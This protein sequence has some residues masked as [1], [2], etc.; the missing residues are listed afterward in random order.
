MDNEAQNSND[1]KA[2]VFR[3]W[4]GC[5]IGVLAVLI[6]LIV[7]FYLLTKKYS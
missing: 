7:L 6:L 4:T 5:Y 3:S 2:P 1:E